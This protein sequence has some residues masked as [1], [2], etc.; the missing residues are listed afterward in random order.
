M[1]N[2]DSKHEG[3]KNNTRA[4]LSVR[5]YDR[6]GDLKTEEIPAGR[7]LNITPEERRI[8]E[9]M[10]V[11]D[12]VNFFK[13]GMLT[14]VRLIEADEDFEEI[15]SNKNLMSEDDMRDLLKTKRGFK[16]SVEQITNI[17]TLRRIAEIASEENADVTLGQM[18]AIQG[19]VEELDDRKVE[20]NEAEVISK[21]RGTKL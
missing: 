16:A 7:V 2:T 14:P 11:T 8:N 5:K 3:W 6:R 15:K 19:R 20:V 12:K 10:A 9:E 4:L 13:N 18:K 17:A 1:R 21:R